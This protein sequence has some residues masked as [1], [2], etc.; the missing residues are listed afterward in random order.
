MII[1]WQVFI[2]FNIY[3]SFVIVFKCSVFKKYFFIPQVP[4]AEGKKVFSSNYLLS[5]Q[6]IWSFLLYSVLGEN[7]FSPEELI[8]QT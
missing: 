1:L 8:L 5:Y 2:L 4:S 3:I 6:S 7:D